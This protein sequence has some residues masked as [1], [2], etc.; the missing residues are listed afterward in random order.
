MRCAAKPCVPAPPHGESVRPS[1]D[2]VGEAFRLPARKY[3]E[4]ALL[5][6]EIEPFFPA[7]R[8]TRPLQSLSKLYAKLQFE[9][10]KAE[11]GPLQMERTFKIMN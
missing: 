6:G 3:H 7:G 11:K 8:E 4:F 10:Q 1:V 2:I 9:M 5:S